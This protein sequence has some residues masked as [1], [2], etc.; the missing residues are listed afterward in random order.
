MQLGG[1]SAVQNKSLGSVAAYDLVKRG[2]TQRLKGTVW[3]VRSTP[4]VKV[5][6]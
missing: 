1:P 5:H 2:F 6:K 3:R 4:Q